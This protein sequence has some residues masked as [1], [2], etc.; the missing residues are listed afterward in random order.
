MWY[1][2][3]ELGVLLVVLGRSRFYSTFLGTRTTRQTENR[4][5]EADK[6][7]RQKLQW[8]AREREIG[9]CRSQFIFKTEIMK[10]A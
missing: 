8:N 10:P 6:N 1:E 3:Y 7:S 9:V 2:L 5:Y 4:K